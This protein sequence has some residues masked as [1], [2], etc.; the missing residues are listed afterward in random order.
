MRWARLLSNCGSA[1]EPFSCAISMDQF[2]SGKVRVVG[3]W[4]TG[5]EVAYSEVDFNA[6]DSN[7]VPATVFPVTDPSTFWVNAHIGTMLNG[8]QPDLPDNMGDPTLK[9]AP[10]SDLSSVASI[11]GDGL[12]A[13]PPPSNGQWAMVS[14]YTKM[15]PVGTEVAM[16]IPLTL[17]TGGH[18]TASI[19]VDNGV[20]LWLDGMHT[21]GAEETGSAT[22]G[23]YMVDLG[24]LQ[25]TH[26]LQFVLED[27]G[28]TNGFAMSITKR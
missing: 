15:W 16:V 22:P 11:L 13:G 9:P 20:F 3:E 4:H 6:F 27:H 1:T 2:C 25:G 10:E 28:V 21:F 5:G 17:N 12:V 8:T 7:T 24:T 26:Y 14:A 19:G 18:V 23:E